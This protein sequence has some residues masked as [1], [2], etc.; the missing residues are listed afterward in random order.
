VVRRRRISRIIAPNV[1]PNFPD[2]DLQ[3]DRKSFVARRRSAAGGTPIRSDDQSPICAREGHMR[4]QSVRSVVSRVSTAGG[5]LFALAAAGCGDVDASDDVT[6]IRSALSSPAPLVN[7]VGET[8]L[9]AGS[10]PP[11]SNGAVSA[12]FVL[13]T[14]NGFLNVKNRNGAV[15]LSQSQQDFWASL[16]GTIAGAF[17]PQARFDPFGQRFIITAASNAFDPVNARLLVAVSQT[18][19]PTGAWHKFAIFADPAQLRWLDFPQLGYNKKWIVAAGT[20]ISNVGELP[21]RVLWVVN[22]TAAYAG[23]LSFNR[24]VFESATPL[25]PAEMYDGV[26]EDLFFLRAFAPQVEN[27]ELM[28]LS[29][30]VGGEVLTTVAV[31]PSP[32]PVAPLGEGGIAILPQAGGQPTP[33]AIGDARVDDCVFRNGSIW[34]VQNLVPDAQPRR[35]SL[36]WLQ[37]STSGALQSFGRID[38]P[39]AQSMFMMSSIAVNGANDFMIGYS[40]FSSSSFPS[41]GYSVHLPGDAPG[42]IR[43]PFV[44]RAGLAPY[45]V[46]RWGDYSHTQVDPANDTDF[47]TIQEASAEQDTWV[48]WWA[49]ASGGAPPVCPPGVTSPKLNLQARCNTQGQQS[50]DFAIRV[51]NWDT[52]PVTIGSL[53]VKAWAFE[54]APLNLSQWNNAAGRICPPGG[55]T[56]T[57]I[58]MTGQTAALA[59]VPACTTDPAHKANQ[60]VTY[61]TTTPL[62]IPANGGSWQTQNDS[63]R[64]GRNNPTMTGGNF[65]DDYSHFGAGNGDCAAFS[66]FADNPFFDLYVNGNRVAE[67]LSASSPD[68]NTGQEPCACE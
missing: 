58:S 62:T 32:L 55:G 68:P 57:N 40:H 51:F 11:D 9:Q 43:D 66:T 67:Q 19:D 60:V 17:D 59:A 29:G 13:S 4:S 39:T 28:R 20:N 18:A 5:L 33:F 36:Q 47:W 14:V 65:A 31:V 21:E 37:I 56:C 25:R 2:L 34:G 1:G 7:F 64:I 44:Y 22:K 41:A 23:T 38:D 53:C 8:Q 16:G 10:I 50:Q 15:L 30:P 35:A 12:A 6:T 48:T 49:Q 63:L 61:C 52:T 42:T 26:I 54:P 45:F 24:I 27:V 3:A 46:N